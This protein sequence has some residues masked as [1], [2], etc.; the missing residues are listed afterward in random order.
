M[1]WLYLMFNG[2]PSG[3]DNCCETN[4]ETNW[5]VIHAEENAIIKCQTR[6]VLW[7]FYVVSDTLTLPEL[8]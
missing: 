2:M 5:N 7:G 3:L 4:G 8:F 6:T 1:V